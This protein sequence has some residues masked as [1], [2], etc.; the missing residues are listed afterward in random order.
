V[1]ATTLTTVIVLLPLTLSPS[2][3]SQKSMAAAMLGGIVA[4]TALTLFALPAVFML[5]LDPGRRR[6]VS[7][8]GKRARLRRK[9]NREAE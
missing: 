3:A 6:L 2:A 4:S 5:V 1:L 7:R 8:F 9:G